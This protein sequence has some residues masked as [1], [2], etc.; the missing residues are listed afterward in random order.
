MLTLKTSVTETKL[1]LDEQIVNIAKVI[2]EQSV[3]LIKL[4]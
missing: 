2:S 1:R 3:K 4:E